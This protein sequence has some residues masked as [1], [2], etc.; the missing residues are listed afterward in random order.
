MKYDLVI[1]TSKHG[2]NINEC[3]TELRGKW[4]KAKSVLIIFGSPAHGVDE[5]L[6]KENIITEEVTDFKINMIPNQGVETIRTEEAVNASL[7]IL[8][9]LN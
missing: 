6:L 7:S 3:I 1:A 8:N 5:H 9:L 2:R 4:E